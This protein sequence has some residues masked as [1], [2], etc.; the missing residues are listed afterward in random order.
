MESNC[1]PAVCAL[2]ESNWRGNGRDES[3]PY[4]IQQLKIQRTRTHAVC[5]Y[6]CKRNKHACFGRGTPRP[7]ICKH[8]KHACFGRGTPRPYICKHNKYRHLGCR[9]TTALHDECCCKC[10]IYIYLCLQIQAIP[11]SPHWRG[12]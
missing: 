8:N 6:I 11:P 7:Y 5:P 10:L 1:V 4:N 12:G 2:G 3:R 9:N